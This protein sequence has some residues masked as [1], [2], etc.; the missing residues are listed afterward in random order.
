MV[1]SEKKD[2]GLG[3]GLAYFVEDKPYRKYLATK[4]NQKEMSSCT[5]LAALDHAN[6]KFSKGYATTGAGIGV[7]ARHEFIQPNGV[8]DLQKGERY[9]LQMSSLNSTLRDL[10]DMRTWIIYSLEYSKTTT[11]I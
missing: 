10:L 6:T 7:C 11:Q 4:T 9:V 1:S 8:G 5:G 2:P 3:T